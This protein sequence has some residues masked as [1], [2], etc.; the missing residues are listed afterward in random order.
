MALPRISLVGNLVSDAELRFTTAGK[1]ILRGRV[2]CSNRIKGEDGQWKDGESCFLDFELWE[3]KAEAFAEVGLKGA[4]V[5]IVGQLKQRTYETNE[6]Q[7]R[8]VYDLSCDDIAL[9]VKPKKDQPAAGSTDPWATNQPGAAD[10][11]SEPPF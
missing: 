6:G 11:D 10:W 8:T 1:A 2:A 7:R 3:R 5:M 4:T 9:V